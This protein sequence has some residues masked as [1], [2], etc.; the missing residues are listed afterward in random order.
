M[1]TA[2]NSLATGILQVGLHVDSWDGIDLGNSAFKNAT[3]TVTGIGLFIIA[4]IGILPAAVGLLLEALVRTGAIL[5]LAATIP[6]LA[7]GVLADATKRWLWTGL[8]WMMALIMMTPT[9][10]LAIVIGVK[11][12]QNAA[13]ASG[14]TA[15][16][17]QAAVQ[18]IIGGLILMIA[19]FCPFALFK[20]FAFVDPNSMS[21]AAVRGYF[22]GGG[23]G[24]SGGASSAGSS[25]G[26]AES[27]S[28]GRFAQA[29]GALSGGAANTA[30]GAAA[31]SNNMLDAVGA[32]HPTEPG[33]GGGG[34]GR[35]GGQQQGGD[36]GGDPDEPSNPDN[37]DG[38][39]PPQPAPPTPPGVDQYGGPVENHGKTDDGDPP[40][41]QPPAP[42][43]PGGGGGGG[44][45]AAAGGSEAAEAAVVVA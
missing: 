41:G 39:D 23:G 32:G 3:D 26:S 9:T 43:S 7:G 27:D 14:S 22:A 34:G 45:G 2:S 35:G 28:E 1:V 25:E 16:A 12:A 30:A 42:P 44:G 20:L 8:R 11:V 33:G 40:G 13:G 4:L 21:G 36:Q 5:I 19:L 29:L 10:A 17:A 18:A 37:G 38:G 31:F 15:G 6:I 24:S